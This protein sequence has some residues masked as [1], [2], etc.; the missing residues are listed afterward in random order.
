MH[1]ILVAALSII[2]SNLSIRYE[3]F[4]CKVSILS[5]HLK[6]RVS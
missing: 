6:L 1:A 2:C 5:T 4:K 3:K